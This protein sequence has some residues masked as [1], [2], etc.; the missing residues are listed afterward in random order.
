M[1]KKISQAFCLRPSKPVDEVNEAAALRVL[2]LVGHGLTHGLGE[3]KPGQM[4]VEAA[5]AYG[6]GYDHS[7][8]PECVSKAISEF[9]IMLND[10]KWFGAYIGSDSK[11]SLRSGELAR[12]R[13]LRAV[14]IAQLGSAQ[15]DGYAFSEALV[16]VFI[17]RV[18]VAYA[19][20]FG[21]KGGVAK[22]INSSLLSALAKSMQALDEGV[23]GDPYSDLDDLVDQLNKDA[24]RLLQPK[25]GR[26]RKPAFM[27]SIAVD[28]LIRLGTKGSKYLYLLDKAKAKKAMAK[29]RK[30]PK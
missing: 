11:K 16:R 23:S 8:R 7:D 10:R 13:G 29:L 25:N 12:A 2:T 6:M 9:K 24:L 22:A 18:I 15:F 19:S 30:Q 28:A 1:P 14:A 5:V 4:C 26:N 20:R 17:D 3:P 27:A 21:V